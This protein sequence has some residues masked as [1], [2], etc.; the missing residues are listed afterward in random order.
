[1]NYTIFET[2]WGYF[3]LLGRSGLLCRANLPEPSGKAVETRL[4]ARGTNGRGPAEFHPSLFADLQRRVIAYYEGEPQ[5]FDVDPALDLGDFTDFERA[6]LTACRC[7]GLGETT[8]YAE[9]AERIGSPGAARA[10][11]NVMAANPLPLIVPCHRVVR[12]DGGLGGFSGGGGTR[13]KRAMLRHE[14]VMTHTASCV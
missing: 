1:V 6:V 12:R 7:V 2:P 3:G 5:A 4:L 14:Q 10:V 11:G 8:T 13:T 9:L